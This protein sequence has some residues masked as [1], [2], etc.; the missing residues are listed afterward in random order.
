MVLLLLVLLLAHAASATLSWTA[1]VG[2]Q[3]FAY[4]AS[5]TDRTPLNGLGAFSDSVLSP[6][7]AGVFTSG[8][9]RR[10]VRNGTRCVSS[11]VEKP[12]LTPRQRPVRRLVSV[13]TLRSALVSP[14]L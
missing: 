9:V 4:D 12:L 6:M 1:V 7:G 13:A 3:Y 5:P 14:Q 11:R 8:T 10:L 2:G